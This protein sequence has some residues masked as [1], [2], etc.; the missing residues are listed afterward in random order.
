M[1]SDYRKLRFVLEFRFN[2]IGERRVVNQTLQR[3]V[4]CR[5]KFYE[6]PLRVGAYRKCLKLLYA[7]QKLSLSCRINLP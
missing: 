1:L 5:S 3:K 4:N 2:T 7:F 6:R